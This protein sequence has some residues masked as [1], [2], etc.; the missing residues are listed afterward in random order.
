MRNIGDERFVELSAHGTQFHANV[1]A[2]AR[3]IG[4]QENNDAVHFR[5][6][7]HH[8]GAGDKVIVNGAAGEVRGVAKRRNGPDTFVQIIFD[9][10]FHRFG[11]FRNHQSG[12]RTGI[13]NHC[14]VAAA[15]G[16]DADPALN[17]F[18][19]GA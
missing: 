17:R 4:E 2:D 12:Q 3:N 1:Q 8:F 19:V 14:A 16:N 5:R 9:F 7:P 11:Q 18:G 13:H 6:R 10:H 15:A